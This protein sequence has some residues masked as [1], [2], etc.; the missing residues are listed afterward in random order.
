MCKLLGI[1]ITL[2]ILRCGVVFAANGDNFAALNLSVNILNNTCTVDANLGTVDMGTFGL[3]DIRNHGGVSKTIPFLVKLKE[4]G[5]FAKSANVSLQGVTMVDEPNVLAL[6][7][8]N[9]ESTAKNIGLQILDENDDVLHI[10]ESTSFYTYEL[11]PGS[12]SVLKFGARYYLSGNNA[13]AGKADSE[14]TVLFSYN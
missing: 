8:P 13:A 11:T 2:S 4:C 7:N 12:D 14:V 6:S 10:N 9:D 5:V 3:R 1:A